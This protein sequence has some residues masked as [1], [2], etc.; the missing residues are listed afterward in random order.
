M[1]AAMNILA[2]LAEIAIVAAGTAMMIV[3]AAS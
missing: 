1:K 2:N 3:V